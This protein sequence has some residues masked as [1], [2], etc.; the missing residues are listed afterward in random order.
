MDSRLGLLTQRVEAAFGEA[1]APQH[2]RARPVRRD[3]LA[4]LARGR[5]TLRTDTLAQTGQITF[6]KPLADGRA[7]GLVH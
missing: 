3:G 1:L 6:R 5:L 2:E 7:I 4:T